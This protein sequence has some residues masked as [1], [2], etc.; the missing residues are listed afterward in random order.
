MST[1]PSISLRARLFSR[2]ITAALARMRG[3]NALTGDETREDM[4]LVAV[5]MRRRMESL[6]ARGPVP[7][8]V[9]LD[10]A[11][12]N[13]IPA[14]WVTHVRSDPSRVVMHVHGGAFVAGSPRT[15]RGIAR[16][17][18]HIAK[19]RVF[20]PE[21]RLAPEHPYPEPLDDAVTA[22]K[23]LVDEEGVP[24][25]RIAVSGDSA[26]GG[27]GLSML[28]RLR[29]EGVPLPACYVGLSP[30]TDLAATGASIEEN[31]GR[32]VMF[33]QIPTQLASVL[34]SL[35]YGDA[36]PTDPLVSPMYADMTG[37]PPMLIHVGESELI[38]DDGLRLVS[39]AR[40]D[41]VHASV[42][43]FHGMWHVFQAFPIPE[44]SWSY[45][46]I[47]GFIRRHIPDEV[48]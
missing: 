31:N 44:A 8:T 12:A 25:H 2:G 18:A 29:D 19:A 5:E 4:A 13:G 34:A 32:D 35:Y 23:W 47:G 28:L 30:W 40:R 7:R 17:L 36:D 43:R 38:R 16:G 48:D 20:M 1:T 27:L 21:Y 42:G 46:E 41:G 15:H 24:P 45:R 22:Y 33:G 14:E 26:G 9:T 6:A 37:M 11:D 3:S 39:R 10:A